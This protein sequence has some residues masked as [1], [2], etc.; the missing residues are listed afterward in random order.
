MKKIIATILTLFAATFAN[1]AYASC[2]TST[3][4]MPDGRMMICTTCCFSG[5]C[6]TTCV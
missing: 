3:I 2:N 4:I 6:T 5:N 1:F